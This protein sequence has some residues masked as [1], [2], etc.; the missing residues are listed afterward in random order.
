MTWK[1]H[2]TI[3]IYTF[4][5]NK[6]YVFFFST[7]AI[8]KSKLKK[9]KKFADTGNDFVYFIL[10][11]LC[12]SLAQ[13][14]GQMLVVVDFYREIALTQRRKPK[15]RASVILLF[16]SLYYDIRSLYKRGWKL[17][18]LFFFIFIFHNTCTKQIK[19]FHPTS[20]E[21]AIFAICSD[22]CP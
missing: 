20:C 2:A 10:M 3:F 12:I 8:I 22:S 6:R 4:H 1:L 14:E 11:H 17:I 5:S 13:T 21:C 19:N 15:K 7:K 16:F 18:L 9:K